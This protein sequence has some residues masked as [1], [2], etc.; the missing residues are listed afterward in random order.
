[1]QIEVAYDTIGALTTTYQLYT[2]ACMTPA[3]VAKGVFFVIETSTAFT[4]GHELYIDNVMLS[5]MHRPVAGGLAC[6]VIPGNTRF[7]TED[8]FTSQ[9]TNNREGEF[10]TE[11]DRMFDMESKG[12]ALPSD[13][14][15]SN[16]S[17]SDGLIG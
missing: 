12:Y 14:S 13:Y 15:G 10:Q 5:E 3:S 9:V 16:G 17:I 8:V 6:Q 2:R 1:M 11:F 7:A 4:A